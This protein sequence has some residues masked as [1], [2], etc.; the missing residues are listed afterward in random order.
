MP[1]TIELDDDL[2]ERI[3]GHLE[4]GETIEEYIA[5]LV[6]IYEQEGRFLQEGA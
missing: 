2:A 6:A 1:R 5:E 3:D 4:D